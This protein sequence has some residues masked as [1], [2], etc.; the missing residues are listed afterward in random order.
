M[1]ENKLTA[2]LEFTESGYLKA[3]LLNAGS[4]R[5]QATLEKALNRLLKPSPFSWIK[6]LFRRE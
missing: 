5:D 2:Q 6:R 1:I 3:I 4:K